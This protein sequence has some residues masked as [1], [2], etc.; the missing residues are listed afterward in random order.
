[1]RKFLDRLR[2]TGHGAVLARGALGVF[3]VKITGAGVL[4]GLHVLLARLLGVGQ[5]GIY[6]YAIS[7]ISIMVVLCLLGFHTSLVRL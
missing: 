5:Y 7:W 6:V 1:M 2:G 3:I 4:F